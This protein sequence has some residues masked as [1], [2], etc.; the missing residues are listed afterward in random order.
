M[1]KF[2]R[3]RIEQ[4][5]TQTI[6]VPDEMPTGHITGDD[7]AEIEAGTRAEADKIIKPG[8]TLEQKVTHCEVIE[9][10]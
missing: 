9:V 2:L 1:T 7:L 8:Q 6:A 10:P 4:V 5:L 3:L